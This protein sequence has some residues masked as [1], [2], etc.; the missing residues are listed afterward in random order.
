LVLRDRIGVSPTV[1][2]KTRNNLVQMKPYKQGSLSL[3]FFLTN[4]KGLK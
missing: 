4:I 2:L 3:T 1:G